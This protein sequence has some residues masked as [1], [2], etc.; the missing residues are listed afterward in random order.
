M[1]PAEQEKFILYWKSHREPFSSTSSKLLRGFPFAAIFA[2]PI[3]LFVGAIYFFLPDWYYKISNTSTA[4]FAVAA[5]AVAVIIIFFAYFR[6][7]FKWEMNEQLYKELLFKKQKE[8]SST[9]NN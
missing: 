1:L 9:I 8:N 5:I 3:L 2:L 7:H 6:M 4:S